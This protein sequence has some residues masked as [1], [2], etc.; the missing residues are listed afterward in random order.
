MARATPISFVAETLLPTVKG[1]YRVR[2]YQDQSE[3]GALEHR[4]IM[5]IVWGRPEQCDNV[6]L[7]VHDACFTSEVLHSLKCDCRQ[8][9]DFAMDFIQSN[10]QQCGIIVYMPQEGRGIGLANKIK[11]YSVQ[12]RGYDTVD[13]NRVLGFPDDLREYS[14]VPSILDEMGVRSVALMTNNPRKTRILAALGVHITG[15]IP[16]VMDTNEHSHGYVAAKRARMGHL[17]E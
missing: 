10:P 1:K 5:V 6:P 8:Q 12:E 13:A 17:A 15:R 14:A 3:L 16:V 11:V 7:R 2:A 4:E 9:L